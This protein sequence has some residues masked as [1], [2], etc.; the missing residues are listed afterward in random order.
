[1]G[2]AS[3]KF[4]L[5]DLAACA[6]I[7][8]K[9]TDWT[10]DGS[11]KFK[12]K[13]IRRSVLLLCML[14]TFSFACSCADDKAKEKEQDGTK[15]E[16][17]SYGEMLQYETEL[18][19]NAMPF[20]RTNIMY[21]ECVTMID[22][23]DG[24]ITAKML[25]TPVKIIEVRDVTLKK[26]YTEGKDYTWNEG[27][28][29]LSWLEGSEIPYFTENDLAGKDQNGNKIPAWGDTAAG[30]NE[31]NPWD[32]LGR[33]RMG[34]ALF[35]VSEFYYSKQI[36]VTYENQ[37]ED[38]QGSVTEYQGDK[39]PKT[40]A[41]LEAGDDLVTY[42][43][44]DSIFVGCDSSKMYGREPRQD[45]F[46]KLMEKVLEEKY[47]G[48]IVLRNPSVG[49]MDS[50]WGANNAQTLVAEK[51]PDLVLIGFGMNDGGKTGEQ[52]ATNIRS[53]ID[54]IRASNPDC[55]F[56]VVT[57]MVANVNSGYLSTQG[58]FSVALEP[59]SGEGVAFVDMFT[60]H[61]DILKRKD[62]SATSGN[63]INHP[64]DWLIRVY[65]MNLIACIMKL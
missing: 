46:F 16:K 19:K 61:S 62:F 7:K 53:I 41:K 40:I 51:S 18:D 20:W 25:L 39:L 27:T 52:V 1:M 30:W 33:G 24:T 6:K 9:S 57:P 43:Y 2:I 48:N 15:E 47:D 59:L 28:N 8:G 17:K 50:T 38:W 49:G 63:H 35:C 56:I 44:G 64:N 4:L 5:T 3:V 58:Q 36:A 55:E 23:G 60:V 45:Y 26:T 10:G 65:A 21:D 13:M 31:S 14:L 29:T 54:T 37:Y 42:I 12:Q 11:M 22:R 34:E 32:A